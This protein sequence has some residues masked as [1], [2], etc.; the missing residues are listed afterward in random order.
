[1]TMKNYEFWFVVGSQFLYGPE[2]LDIVAKRAQEM[3]A[4]LSKSLPYPL[5]YKVTAKTNKEIR[6][7]IREANFDENCAGIITWCHTFSPSKMWINGFANLQKPYCHLATQYNM[8]IP[9]EEIDMDFMNLNQAAHGDRE[10]GFIAARM[11]MPRKIIAGYWKEEGVQ[12][13]IGDWMKSAVGVAFSKQLKVMRFG[14]NM[15]EVAVTE[16]DK[17]EVQIK[18]GWEV[19]T[20]PVG[21]LVEYMNAVTEEEVDA[22]MAAY[23]AKYEM[24]TDDI[25]T[26]RYQAREEIAIKK[27][28]DRE[29]CL[30]F[31]NTFQDL[32]GMEQLP[33]IASQDLMAQGYGYGGEGDWKVSAM[34][35]IMKAMGE[36]GNGASAF[37][38]DYTYHLVPGAKN[39]LGAH[40]LEVCPS[41]AAAKP[42]IEVHPLGIGDRQPPARLVF[43]GKEGDAIV[44][45]LVD[46]GGRLRLICQDIHCVK[47]IMD[48]PN[49]PVARVMWQAMPDLET[50]IECW[51][52]A[53]GAHHSVLSYDVSAEQMK[54]WA[55][56]MDIEFVHI[57]KDTTVESLEKELFLNDLA[58]KLK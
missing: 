23:E 50:G 12:K 3:A 16:G 48:M 28:M 45:S 47:P 30:A 49:L 29:G 20:W 5:V 55:R 39:S 40:M 15:R 6:D 27:M 10:H 11:R 17:V 38:E 46:M 26:V 2:V 54:D 42:R 25:A 1:M 32:Y 57:T 34:T 33:G 14:D 35:A 41:L 36:N 56:M 31:S 13:R 52:T 58:W 7:V 9:N 44:V 43:E 8:E 22:Q 53:G 37:M 4:E 24:A 19:N 21:E 18:L 51:I